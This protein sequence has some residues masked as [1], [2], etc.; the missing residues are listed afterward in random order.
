MKHIIT[1]TTLTILSS[2]LIIG[3][4]SLSSEAPSHNSALNSV[5]NSNGKAKDGYMQ[6]TM[7]AWFANDWT[8]TISQDPEIQKKYMQV[9]KTPQAQT[10]VVEQTY[11]R[12]DGATKVVYKDG[13]QKIHYV[14]KDDKPFTL[15]EYVDKA[16]A[17][18]K[19]HPN[20]YEHSN[21]KKLES[22][23]VIGH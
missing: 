23:P 2:S 13:S 16:R 21:V 20:D 12:K 17:Y 8:P 15:Q 22:M 6:K 11:I 1:K 18:R 19:A 7:K 10:K 3:C 9:D 4:S 5:S 14:E